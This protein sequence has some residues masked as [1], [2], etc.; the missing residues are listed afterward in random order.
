MLQH[1]GGSLGPYPPREGE[2]CLL[3]PQPPSLQHLEGDNNLVSAV[4]F[5]VVEFPTDD[6]QDVSVAVIISSPPTEMQ[7]GSS[8]NCV[9][10]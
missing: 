7:T 9:L 2:P 6:C 5:E 10:A 8:D 3:P 4:V 1:P